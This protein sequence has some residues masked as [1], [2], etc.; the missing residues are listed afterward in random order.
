MWNRKEIKEKTKDAVYKNEI[1]CILAGLILLITT[2]N[3]I[4]ISTTSSGDSL[5]EIMHNFKFRISLFSGF[6]QVH[7]TKQA[8]IIASSILVI[9]LLLVAPVIVG[10]KKFFIKNAS[11]KALVKDNI[12]FPFKNHF[13]NLF[14][15]TFTTKVLIFLFS[16]LLLVPGIIAFYSWRMVPYILAD[17]PEMSGAEARKCSNELMEGNR[18]KTFV[19]DLSFIGWYLF[20]YLTFGI[21]NITWTYPYHY[22]AEANLY[23]ALTNANQNKDSQT[24]KNTEG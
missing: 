6:F 2:G 15:A 1:Q 17:N 20:G 8:A 18:W 24:P 9:F 5:A 14:V 4:G 19:F 11:D 16:L 3:F 7:A 23:L 22:Q 13:K 12:T 10:M 21:I